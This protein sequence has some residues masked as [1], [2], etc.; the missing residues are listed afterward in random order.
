MALT[1]HAFN[2]ELANALR[3]MHPRWT[4]EAERTGRIVGQPGRRP[5]ITIDVPRASP[6]VIEIEFEP[7]NTVEDDAQARLDVQ[8]EGA[9][10]PVETVVALIVPRRMRDVPSADLHLR[11]AAAD[12]L[13]WAVLRAGTPA[14]RLPADGWMSG[15]LRALA[16]TLETLAVSVRRLDEAA[17]TLET[18]VAIGVQLLNDATPHVRARVARELRQAPDEATEHQTWRMASVI[19]AKAFLFQEAIAQHYSTPS[20]GDIRSTRSET[21]TLDLVGTLTAWNR[22][23]EIDYLP[24]FDIATRLLRAIPAPTS[25][26][27]CGAMST[28]AFALH[29][30]GANQ[31]QDMTGQ[32]FGRMIVDRKF[33]ATFYTLPSA[34]ALL[35]ELALQQLDQRLDWGDPSSVTGLRVADF[36][37][38]TGVLLSAA[39]Q[40][41]RARVR[42]AGLDDADLH[43]AMI[44]HVLIGA[45][46]MPA[47]AHLTATML[48]SAHPELSFGHCGIHLVDYGRASAYD[49]SAVGADAA[50]GPDGPVAVG[51]LDLLGEQGQVSSL[52]VRSVERVSG[53]DSQAVPQMQLDDHSLDL[54]IMNP[55][56]TRPTNH[57]TADAAGVPV[58]SFAGFETDPA[59]QR[60]MSERL[61]SLMRRV[62]SLRAGHGNAG[63]A[64]NFV[65]LAFAKT[66]PGGVMA[67]VLPLAAVTG[68]SWAASR[69]LLD[70][71]CDEV[72]WVGLAA[73]GTTERAF[74]ADTGMA[75]ALVIA[76]KSPTRRRSRAAATRWVTLARRPESAT[77]AVWVAQSISDAAEAAP[78]YLRVGDDTMGHV[79]PASAN[80]PM[81]LA[82]AEPDLVMCATALAEGRL[83]LPRHATVDVS[84]CALAELGR[85]GP[86]HRDI[87]G[88]HP[89]TGAPRGPFD[90]G[91]IDPEHTPSYPILWA[92]AAASGRESALCVAPDFAGLLRS[93]MRVEAL[94]TWAT[95]TRLHVNCDFR[96]NSQPLGGCMT[97]EPVIGGRAWPSFLLDERAW[98]PVI[99]LWLNTTLGLVARWSVSTRQQQ[100]RASLTITTLGKI[101]VLNPRHLSQEQIDA[102]AVLAD[103]IGDRPMLPANEAYRDGARQELDRALLAGILGLP[104]SIFESLAVLQRQ[105]CEE[106][107][108]HGGKSTRP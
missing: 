44:E 100:G 12:D 42:R 86:V 92:H 75:E 13:R 60:A 2:V 80:G 77:A 99:A 51:S 35:A 33:L 61:K 15:S 106:P 18:A 9:P 8:I 38:G 19:L 56:F 6:L 62:G 98:E 71:H 41:I 10:L 53:T 39:Y 91:P 16:D 96:V 4:V 94:K 93:G 54:C 67:L 72:T 57:E 79:Q 40:R 23:L 73:H 74:S 108:V 17:D 65:D 83:A 104:E 3:R 5:D 11:L 97:S 78:S 64:S 25:S 26:F 43:T 29:E 55:P 89:S 28:A 50:H 22:I 1:E 76:R 46:V 66:K 45:D 95:A 34:A 7:A 49:R 102:C 52:L 48:A 32:M 47:A 69:R 30:A 59:D 103:G 36:A 63:L 20:I 68:N 84:T 85:P 107:S 101:P 88:A 14:R 82:V 81:L 24:I 21:H 58:P 87:N 31:V 70:K 90:L 105:W 37:C 27:L